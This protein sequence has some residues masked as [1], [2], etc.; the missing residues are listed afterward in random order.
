VTGQWLEPEEA[1]YASV[2][3][4][5]GF[6]LEFENSRRGRYDK[7]TAFPQLSGVTRSNPQSCDGISGRISHVLPG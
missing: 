5:S 3:Q 1:L 6:W 2:R 4:E 7:T